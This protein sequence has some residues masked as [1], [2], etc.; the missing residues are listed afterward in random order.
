MS[1]LHSA[2]VNDVMYTLSRTP[3]WAENPVNDPTGLNGTDCNYY[4]SGSPDQSRSAGQ[5][6]PPIDLNAD[7]SGANQ[8]WKNWVSAI[9]TKVNDP[10]YLAN[11]AHIKYWEPWNEWYRSTVLIPNYSGLLSF[12]G[13]Y[14]QMVRL[15]EDVRC[16][17][18][19]KGTIHNYP[20]AGQS[21]PCTATA[22]D[23]NAV[24]VSPSLSP[25][26]QGGIDVTQNFLYCSGTGSHA[27]APGSQCTT[28][29][30]GSQAIDVMNYHMYA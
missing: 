7:G 30:A 19:G 17:I 16:T 26:F 9:A 22:I 18:T 1:G 5:C 23:P 11:H 8:L 4:I 3:P 25:E 6:M 28:G 21:T 15:T 14:A 2:G 27:P 10:T 20:A 24:I 29:N 12:Q 13:T